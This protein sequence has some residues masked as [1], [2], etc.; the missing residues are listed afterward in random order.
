MWPAVVSVC[1]FIVTSLLLR[2]EHGIMEFQLQQR[3]REH[4]TVLSY[5]YIACLVLM[6]IYCGHKPYNFTVSDSLFSFTLFQR[7]KQKRTNLMFMDP[8]IV[9]QSIIVQ[10]V[11]T[12]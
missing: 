7:C 12:M 2:N 11:A 4:V 10:Q 6:F 3:L 8:C 5:T 9:N 1:N